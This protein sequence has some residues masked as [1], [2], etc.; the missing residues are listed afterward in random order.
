MVMN[1]SEFTLIRKTDLELTQ[2]ELS[3]EL[4]VSKETISNIERSHKRV[5]RVYELAILHVVWI[6]KVRP[7]ILDLI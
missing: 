7:M 5:P 2:R 1:P 6:R 4:E 3:V